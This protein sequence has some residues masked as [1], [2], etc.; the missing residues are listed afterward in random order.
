MK[1]LASFSGRS[2]YVIWTIAHLDITL[3]HSFSFIQFY[4]FYNSACDL[5]FACCLFV[6]FRRLIC[7]HAK[8]GSR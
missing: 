3:D 7:V 8:T 1:F 4:L 2:I 5:V 6:C